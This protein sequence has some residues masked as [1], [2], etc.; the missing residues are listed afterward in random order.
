MPRE[1][2]V[3]LCTWKHNDALHLNTYKMT[4]SLGPSGLLRVFGIWANV[5]LKPWYD[6]CRTF[7]VFKSPPDP[8]YLGSFTFRAL[9]SS[10]TNIL[11]GFTFFFFSLSIGGGWEQG[12]EERKKIHKDNIQA[13]NVWDSF[14]KINGVFVNTSIHCDEAHGWELTIEPDFCVIIPI[15]VKQKCDQDN[16]PDHSNWGESSFSWNSHECLNESILCMIYSANYQ[17]SICI[18]SFYFS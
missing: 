15:S 3:T 1:W 11:G 9:P 8:T 12:A 16:W 17:F 10:V 2:N 7:W 6:Q 13:I 14:R 4:F 18:Y 5:S